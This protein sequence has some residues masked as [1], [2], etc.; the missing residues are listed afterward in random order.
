MGALR[1][2]DCRGWRLGGGYGHAYAGSERGDGPV[3][4]RQNERGNPKQRMAE[5]G[6]NGNHGP[7]GVKTREDG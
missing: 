3:N 7:E 4:G 1:R 6:Q 2:G 5:D